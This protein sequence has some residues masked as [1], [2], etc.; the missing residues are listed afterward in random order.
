MDIPFTHIK[1]KNHAALKDQLMEIINTAE[2]G[3]IRDNWNW[4]THTDWNVDKNAKRAYWDIFWND[5]KDDFDEL[6]RLKFRHVDYQLDNYWFQQYQDGDWHHWHRHPETS[7]NCVYYLEKP[8]NSPDT[9]FW[10]AEKQKVVS[11]HVEEG[12]ILMFPSQVVHCV[13]EVKGGQRTVIVWNFK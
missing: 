5:V 9:V 3:E 6:L 2:G 4:V 13:P 10:D 7:W 11:G 8:D 12:D 1:H